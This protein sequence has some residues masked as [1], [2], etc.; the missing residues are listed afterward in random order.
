MLPPA[1]VSEFWAQRMKDRKDEKGTGVG[2]KKRQR[3]EAKTVRRRNKRYV[4][5]SVVDTDRQL[6]EVRKEGIT[7]I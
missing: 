5:L 3:N 4:R 2:I 1:T 6:R 7:Y